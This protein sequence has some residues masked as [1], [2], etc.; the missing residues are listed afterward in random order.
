M[1]NEVRKTVYSTTD[2]LPDDACACMCIH[3]TDMTHLSK[4]SSQGKYLPGDVDTS[5]EL[6]T[7]V[8]RLLPDVRYECVL[9]YLGHA[10]FL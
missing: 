8:R 10:G 2:E 9:Q 7:R 4:N 6:K 5:L 3:S 1:Y